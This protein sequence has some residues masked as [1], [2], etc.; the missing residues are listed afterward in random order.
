M[1]LSREGARILSIKVAS[2][3]CREV[4]LGVIALT[5]LNCVWIKL[6]TGALIPVLVFETISVV[7]FR[8]PIRRQ[9]SEGGEED[10]S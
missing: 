10:G 9:G 5:T 7:L 1:L 2:I 6:S 8:S 4:S 3:F